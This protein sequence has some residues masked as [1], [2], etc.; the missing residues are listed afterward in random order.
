VTGG[1]EKIDK[2]QLAAS[3]ELAGLVMFSQLFGKSKGD[4]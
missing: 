1:V 2:K 4:R 3:G